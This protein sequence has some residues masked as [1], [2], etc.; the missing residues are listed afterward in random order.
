M[1]DQLLER[2]LDELIRHGIPLAGGTQLQHQAFAKIAC[3][4]AWRIEL[5]N[6]C[7]HR[8]HIV[9][10]ERRNLG[11]ALFR[12]RLEPL[13]HAALDNLERTGEIAVVG[14]VANEIIRQNRFARRHLD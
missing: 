5:L 3:A 8:L 14:N 12:F 9:V 2:V 11:V 4:D 10:A 13:V 1:C 7:E 6:D